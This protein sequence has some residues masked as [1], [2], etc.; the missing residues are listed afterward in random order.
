MKVGLF[1]GSFAG[2]GAEKMMV[3]LAK[4]LYQK[5]MQPI[6]YVANATGPYYEDVPDEIHIHNYNAKN[7]VKSVIHKIRHTLK[8]DGLAAFISTQMHI[9]SAVA[10]ASLG[11]DKRPKLIF[12]EASIPSKIINSKVYAILYKFL[13]RFA[14]H[15]IAIS[16]GVKKNM[17]AYYDLD[18]KS[19]S[20]VYS[21]VV[22]KNLVRLAK[23]DPSHPWLKSKELPT[24]V[25]MGR[26][27]PS[28][29]FVTLIKA[30][31]LVNK[32]NSC[33][34]IIYGKI[35]DSLYFDKLNGLINELNLNDVIDFAG[36]TSNPYSA[37]YN[38]DM[39]IQSPKFE[40]FGNVLV[41]ALAC[42]CPVVS[43]D[44]PSGPKEI[45]KN[46]KYGALVEVGDYKGLA[47]EILNTMEKPFDSSFPTYGAHRFSVE[48]STSE[49]LKLIKSLN[50]H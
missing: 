48:S 5:G 47:K 26:I 28:K 3:N 2:G 36:F 44:C 8:N 16:K 20:V 23:V 25:A 34:L 39:F 50:N 22:S 45:L 32:N 27:I 46:G 42:G 11:V 49:Y 30:I 37:F 1:I 4:G 40:G 31:S 38:A 18:L 15:Y 41:E 29:D 6:I 33:R 7:G 35:D 24:F 13:Y 9:N 19:I 17:A 43:T 12:R 21:P 14:D 10:L